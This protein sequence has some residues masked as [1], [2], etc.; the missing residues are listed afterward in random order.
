MPERGR[1]RQGE[2]GD[3]GERCRAK[4]DEERGKERRKQ[5]KR[6]GRNAR[7][8]ER[9][10]QKRER[11]QDDKCKE[12]YLGRISSKRR[13]KEGEKGAE[14]GQHSFR[15]RPETVGAKMG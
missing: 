12:E 1:K 9:R 7:E 6:Q 14:R 2:R 10:I 8:V 11:L 13:W 4:S 5:R 3:E 15:S